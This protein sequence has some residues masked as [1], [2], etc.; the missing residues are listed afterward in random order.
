MKRFLSKHFGL[1]FGLI[2]A[3]F[4]LALNFF[5]LQSVTYGQGEA[6]SLAGD[7]RMKDDP[8]KRVVIL[9]QKGNKLTG[10]GIWAN[11]KVSFWIKGTVSAGRVDDLI[12]FADRSDVA[13]NSQ[14]NDEI[15]KAAVAKR[16]NTEHPEALT[17]EK[18]GTLVLNKESNVLTGKR[19]VP[20]LKLKKINGKDEFDELE[21]DVLADTTL[22]RIDTY[23]E[24][25]EAE[26]GKIPAFNCLDGEVLKITINGKEQFSHVD[27]CD[28][29]VQLNIRD[30]GKQGQCVPFSRLVVNLSTGRENVITRAICRKYKDSDSR[31][32]LDPG[33]DDI[34]MVSHDT[35]TGNTCFFQSKPGVRVNAT[36]VPSPTDTDAKNIWEPRQPSRANGDSG[37]FGPAGVRCNNCHSAG[38][39]FWSPYVG[40]VQKVSNDEWNPIDKYNSNFD[41]M[42][43]TKSVFFNLPSE[44]NHCVNCHRIGN[45]AY[46]KIFVPRYTNG[47]KD[48]VTH[49]DDFWMPIEDDA[50]TFK[51]KDAAGW[52]L[53]YKD[54]VAQLATCC[55]PGG[56][57]A[58]KPKPL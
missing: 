29:P 54:S 11:G 14:I 35:D 18:R 27:E 56:Q 51:A 15:W 38:P 21:E 22:A 20:K 37:L 30:H 9:E 7:W 3:S 55:T 34:A 16:V 25:C 44:T 8:A 50:Q 5:A 39:F 10:R 48:F 40:Q 41:N 31:G 53:K 24:M 19:P 45:G 52:T 2:G 1:L 43:G 17:T 12:L 42:F 36:H 6:P 33:F 32:K 26:M 46:C 47:T 58:C 57:A 13:K 49:P 4:C 28:N 23:A